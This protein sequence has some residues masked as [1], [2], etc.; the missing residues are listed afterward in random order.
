MDAYLTYWKPE[1]VDWT[2]STAD[3]L[4]HAAC[5]QFT[6]LGRGDRIYFVTKRRG[7]FWLVGAITVDCAVPQAEAGERQA[8]PIVPVRC[9]EALRKISVLMRGQP[10][11]L[12]E[13]LSHRRFLA[14]RK[15]TPDSAALLDELL[16]AGRTA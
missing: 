8:T 11:K 1:N 15:I 12:Q 10:V 4:N 3:F 13:P 7:E 6:K 5:D 2:A 9:E 16:S 14:L